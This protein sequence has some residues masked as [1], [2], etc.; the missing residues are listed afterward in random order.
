MMCDMLKCIITLECFTPVNSI[1]LYPQEN[2][3]LA[4]SIQMVIMV[5]KVTLAAINLHSRPVQVLVFD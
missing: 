4:M 2:A 5:L 3:E 1:K